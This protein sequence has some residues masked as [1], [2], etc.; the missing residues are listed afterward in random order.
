MAFNLKEYIIYRTEVKRELFNGEVDDN[1]KAVANPWVD[2]RTYEEGHIVYH[3]VEVIEPTGGTSVSSEALVWWRANKRTTRGVFDQNE[4]DIIGGIG[5]G[6]ITVGASPGFGKV[7]LNYTGATGSFQTTDD[8][9]LFS[10]TPND[11]FRLI[12]GPG[13]SLQYD[14]TTN[15][16]KLINTGASGEVNQGTNIGVGGNNLFAGMSGT[17]LTF[18]GLTATNTTGTPLTAN[19]DGVN[20]NVVYNFDESEV[21]LANLNS[22][23]PTIS[24]LSNVNAPSPSNSDILQWNGSNWINISPA[25]AGLTGDTGATGPQGPAGATG[26]VGA[27][28]FGATGVQGPTGA[29]GVQGPQGPI[30][31]TGIGE[32]GATGVDGPQGPQGPQGEIGGNGPQGPPGVDGP[33]GATGLTG[34]TGADG[35]FGG[36]SFTYDFNTVTSVADPG[37]GYVSLN[38]ATQNTSTIM[39]INDTAYTGGG[40]ISTFLQTIDASTSIPK[41]HVRISS[42]ADATE[43]ILF[44]ISDLTD[45]TGWWE[46]DVVPIASTASSPFTM[47]EEVIVSFVVTGDKG[48]TGATGATGLTGATGAG[49]IGATGPQGPQGPIGATGAGGIGATGIQGPQGLTGATGVGEIGA[50][51][52]QGPQ[53]PQGIQGVQ[54]PQGE[55]GPIGATGIGS[56]GATG[57]DGATGI[58]GPQGP[59]GATG[60]AG[61]ISGSIAYGE[62]YQVDPEGANTLNLSTSYVGWDEAIQGELNQMSYVASSGPPQGDTLVISAGEGG[63]YQISAAYTV[64]LNANAKLTVAVHKNGN[65]ISSTVSSRSMS[66]NSIG[67]FSTTDLVDLTAGDVIDLRFKVDSGTP[68]LTSHNINFNLTKVVGNGLTGATG[69]QG[70]V[71]ATGAGATGVQGPIGATGVQGPQGSIGATGIGETG[72]T[73]IQGPQGPQ[74]P[75]GSIGATGVQGPG[76][77]TGATGVQGPQGPQGS[78]GATGIQGPQ[79]PQGE[80]GPQ[81]PRGIQG[82][83]GEQGP[84]GPQGE[85]G[86]QGPQGETGPQGPQGE[87]GPQGPQGET[88]PQGPQG[89]TGA[90]GAQ[91][92][93]AGCEVIPSSVFRVGGSVAGTFA[94]NSSTASGVTQIFISNSAGSTNELPLPGDIVSLTQGTSNPDTYDVTAIT[95]IGGSP[96][97]IILTV[98]HAAGPNQ[99]F[100]TST[101]TIYCV[102]KSGA[103]G[104]TGATGVQGPQGPQGIQGVQGPQG[105]IGTGVTGPQGPQGPIGATGP[106][107]SGGSTYGDENPIAEGA[108]YF[109]SGVTPYTGGIS[110]QSGGGAAE[111][112]SAYDWTNA[113][114]SLSGV[115]PVLSRSYGTH[116]IPI[117][118]DIGADGTVYKLRITG[119]HVGTTNPPNLYVGLFKWTCGQF[120][121]GN[122]FQLSQIGSTDNTGN[123]TNQNDALW[124]KCD[125]LT[126]TPGTITSAVNDRLVIGW[127]GTGDIASTEPWSLVWKLWAEDNPL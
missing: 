40:D 36:A 81:G 43:F 116:M 91:I 5:S 3:P 51:G 45:N 54:G 77:E 12:A 37:F 96:G 123:W 97:A 103:T 14:T 7:V 46:I 25:A 107:G 79:G 34:A 31:A 126:F 69:V 118:N 58:Q 99:T 105:P 100:T 41:G 63:V 56:I 1:F 83:Q 11:T 9:T 68:A 2:D 76:G 61:V 16:I 19:L 106:A 60:P 4:W 62:M 94:V 84:Q 35:T 90:A 20:N 121:S 64:S 127:A 38:N 115:P 10:T 65:P 71:G 23:S 112:W 21:D 32:T 101:E 13:M 125:T 26:P 113:I 67:S 55:Q 85:T 74:G 17:T 52:P 75:Q 108:I 73:G 110:F 70:P 92:V 78:I 88:G 119:T 93:S 102:A 72:A 95:P 42:S 53:G 28:G 86:P 117:I 6:D 59:T 33:P 30:G 49:G 87:T 22:G 104:P 111:G 109:K 47:D 24:M 80:A 48:E 82:P 44:Q 39:S 66:N 98:S 120:S 114:P 18:R 29:T 57:A 124:Y 122:D 15:S 89:P 8:G 50:T 27:T